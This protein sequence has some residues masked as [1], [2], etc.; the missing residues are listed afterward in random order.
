MPFTEQ[1]RL[2]APWSYL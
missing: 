2:F 1:F